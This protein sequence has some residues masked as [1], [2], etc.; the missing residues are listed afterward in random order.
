MT[1]LELSQTQT[2]TKIFLILTLAAFTLR[3]DLTSS[4]SH[5]IPRERASSL[6]E[7]LDEP[8]DTPGTCVGFGAISCSRLDVTSVRGERLADGM[9]A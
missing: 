4:C 7:T 5:T 2:V 6:F 1:Q 3:R 8:Y 9:F